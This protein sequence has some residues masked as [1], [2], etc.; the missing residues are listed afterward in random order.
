MTMKKDDYDLVAIGQRMKIVRARLR[1][2]QAMMASE[3]GVSLSHYSKL[4]VGIGGMS[5][6]LIYTFCRLFEIDQEWFLYGTGEEPVP[7]DPVN[8]P[9]RGNRLLVATGIT[10]SVAVENNLERIIELTLDPQ[11]NVLADQIA[12]AMQINKTRAL[13]MLIKE[14]IAPKK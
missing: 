11:V 1:K 9:N 14:Q 12:Q 2:T 8:N 10:G 4:E 13:A 7:V 6:G 5:H 3:L